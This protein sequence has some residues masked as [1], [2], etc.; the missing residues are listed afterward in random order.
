MMNSPAH[1][2]CPGWDNM[3]V[4]NTSRHRSHRPGWDGMWIEKRKLYLVSVAHSVPSGTVEADF[5]PSTNMLCLTAQGWRH[6][7]NAIGRCPVLLM[8]GG[9]I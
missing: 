2:A 9:L 8:S 5:S 4:E 7:P 1:I 3:L 6:L